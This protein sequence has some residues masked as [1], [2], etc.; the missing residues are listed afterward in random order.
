MPIADR[1][2][3]KCGDVVALQTRADT[4]A[5]GGGVTEV[6]T[7]FATALPAKVVEVGSQDVGG[8]QV[9]E[10]VTH[11]VTI[12]ERAGSENTEYVLCTARAGTTVSERYRVQRM[13]LIGPVGNRFRMLLC[14][15]V[16]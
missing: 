10:G 15:K 9:E 14:E 3:A 13:R 8:E 6:Y 11:I 4:A 1:L 5:V 16:E 12:S 2:F 7:S